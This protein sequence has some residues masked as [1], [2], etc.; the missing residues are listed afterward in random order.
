MPQCLSPAQNRYGAFF[1]ALDE[2]A[3]E[4]A[5]L[6]EVEQTVARGAQ[7]E[8]AYLALSSLTHGY[9]RLARR[10]AAAEHEDP[11]VTQRLARWN[12]LLAL[13]YRESGGDPHY[14]AAVRRAAEELSDRAEVRVPCLDARGEP[15][16]CRSTENVLR[17]FSAASE[18]V[19]IRGALERLL[20]RVFGGSTKGGDEG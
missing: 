2:G 17:G 12:D 20:K 8:Q 19:G 5:A 16:H 13:A 7:E 4:D 15:S 14:Q 11:V 1:S 9:Y 3:E 6:A 10:A 18:D